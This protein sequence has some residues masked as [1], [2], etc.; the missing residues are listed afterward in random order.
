M[1]NL[2]K[3]AKFLSVTIVL[4]ASGTTSAATINSSATVTV[5]NVILLTEDA[6]LNFGS[7]R[8][9]AEMTAAIGAVLILDPATGVISA[10]A[11]VG[12]ATT[13]ELSSLSAGN[14][15]SYSVSD[16]ATFTELT[17]TL[18]STAITLAASSVPTSNPVFTVDNFTAT[19]VGTGQDA[20]LPTN[21][22]TDATG[23]VSFN[24]GASLGTDLSAN[25]TTTYIDADYTGSYTITVVY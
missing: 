17:L 15:G 14:A 20:T 10:G 7:V 16:A 11:N 25:T 1:N 6:A 12:T 2:N 23:A 4:A 9:T 21:L 19:V 8:A 5:N 24:V 3:I 18:P 22:I 13:A